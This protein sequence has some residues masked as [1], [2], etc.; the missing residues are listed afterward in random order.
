MATPFLGSLMSCSW[1][2]A[3]KGYAWCNGQLL[4]IS[5]NQAL[6]SLLGTTFGGDGRTNF[7]LPN[8]IGR[9][10]ISFGR[11]NGLADYT[12]GQPGGEQAHTLISTEMPTHNHT[13]F[14]TGAPSAL[15]KVGGN[16]LGVTA[17]PVPIYGPAANLSIMNPQAV[18][19][20]GNSQPHENRQPFLVINW[21]IALVGIFPSQN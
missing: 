1:Q 4:P 6:F 13:M 2:Y 14:A 9:T 8:L 21:V 19:M 15:P 5:V 7:G 12:L 3:T 18:S 11:G 16:A 17:A 20:A 10:P